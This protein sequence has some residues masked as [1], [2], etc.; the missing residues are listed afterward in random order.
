MSSIPNSA[1]NLIPFATAEAP[2]K[3]RES[4]KTYHE[5]K[6]LRL[7]EGESPEPKEKKSKRKREAKPEPKQVLN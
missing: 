1:L 3:V 7:L 6:L 2:P 5:K 4:S